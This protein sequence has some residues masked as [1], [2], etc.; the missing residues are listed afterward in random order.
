MNY[1]S[2][3][4]LSATGK[5]A[6]PARAVVPSERLLLTAREAAGLLGVSL[7]L[8]HSLRPG[9]PRPVVLAQRAVRW[10]RS[11]L[12]SHIESLHAVSAVRPEPMQLAA[13]K[14]PKRVSGGAS[15][16]DSGALNADS[17]A[18]RGSQQSEVPS[19]PKD[20]AAS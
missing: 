1:A 8:F 17:E 6:R 13:G 16:A 20:G 9:L 4:H 15:M 2:T 11:D 19:N 10:R 7:R 18:S 5:T 12:T 3:I 14:A